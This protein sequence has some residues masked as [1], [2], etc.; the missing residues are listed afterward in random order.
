MNPPSHSASTVPPSNQPVQWLLSCS[1]CSCWTLQPEIL[2]TSVFWLGSTVKTIPRNI[3]G[4]ARPKSRTGKQ[5]FI[6]K[7]TKDSKHAQMFHR[8]SINMCSSRLIG[9]TY[10]VASLQGWFFSIKKGPQAPRRCGEYTLWIFGLSR[11]ARGKSWKI[12]MFDKQTT[13]NHLYNG[14]FFRALF[15]NE[16]AIFKDSTNKG[17]AE[18]KTMPF[19]SNFG[20]LI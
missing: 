18:N 13:L 11:V 9:L 7:C 16:M 6:N 15:N 2:Q 14:S 5:W 17:N 19:T 20:W 3:P 4:N 10:C 12:T 1:F 8:K